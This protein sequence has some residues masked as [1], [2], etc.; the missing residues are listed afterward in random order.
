L[1]PEMN[2]GQLAM[3]VR[4][5]YLVDAESFTKVQGQPILAGDVE[6]QLVRRLR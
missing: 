3:M 6:E 4:A 5:R 2:M 1:I